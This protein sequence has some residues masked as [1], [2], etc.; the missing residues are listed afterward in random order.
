MSKTT[1]V[2][3]AIDPFGRVLHT[4]YVDAWPGR[5]TSP[6]VRAWMRLFVDGNSFRLRARVADPVKDLGCVPASTPPL[7][8]NSKQGA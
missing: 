2:V 5:E 8:T 6:A 3:E 1:Y 7:M 4:T